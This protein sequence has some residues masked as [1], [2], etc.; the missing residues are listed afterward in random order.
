MMNLRCP[1]FT[2]AT[3]LGYILFCWHAAK[4]SREPINII[5]DCLNAMALIKMELIFVCTSIANLLQSN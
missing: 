4:N 1:F 3:I 5:K 2:V